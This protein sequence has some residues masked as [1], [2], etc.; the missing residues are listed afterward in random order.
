MKLITALILL[1]APVGGNTAPNKTAEFLSA[2]RSNGVFF[3]AGHVSIGSVIYAGHK[4]VR[5][6][7]E[8][9]IALRRLESSQI[10]CLFGDHFAMP[11]PKHVLETANLYCGGER[12]ILSRSKDTV[13]VEY[14]IRLLVDRKLYA[15][16]RWYNYV[17]GRGVTKIS[18][19]PQGLSHDTLTLDAGGGLLASK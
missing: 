12:F 7:V 15:S 18:F 5:K 11:L 8:G 19:N 9:N 6:G 1:A 14:Y 17:P 10:T 13:T 16:P 4:A 3:A 2:D